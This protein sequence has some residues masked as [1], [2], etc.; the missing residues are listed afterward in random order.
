MIMI[1]IANPQGISDEKRESISI[2][3][4]QPNPSENSEILHVICEFPLKSSPMLELVD[5]LGIVHYSIQSMQ[6]ADESIQHIAI[7]LSKISSGMY[8]IRLR[9]H[10][11]TVSQK[12]I[13]R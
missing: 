11:Q 10:T 1:T 7:P 13:I 6:S 2:V 4:V 9:T 8:I 5:M 12:F 3:S